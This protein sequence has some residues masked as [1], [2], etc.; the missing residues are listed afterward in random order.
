VRFHLDAVVVDAGNSRVTWIPFR[1]TTPA[2]PKASGTDLIDKMAEQARAYGAV[3]EKN[4]VTRLERD[5]QNG[6][7]IAEWGSGRVHARAVLLATGVSTAALRW[8]SRCMTK[9]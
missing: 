9:R 4:R 2:I 7:F 6:G 8:K 3:I 1:T 5:E